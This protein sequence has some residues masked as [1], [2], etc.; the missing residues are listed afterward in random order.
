MDTIGK[1]IMALRKAKGLTQRE[2]GLRVGGYTRQAVGLWENDKR[3]PDYETLTKIAKEL[4]TTVSFLLL[5]HED[6]TRLQ[7]LRERAGLSRQELAEK[8]EV[9]VQLIA[10]VEERE[11]TLEG[12]DLIKV[13]TALN[14][15]AAFLD[16][17]SDDPRIRTQLPPELEQLVDEIIKGGWT[18]DDVR[19]ALRMLGLARGRQDDNDER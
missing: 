16:G 1:R 3:E 10:Q 6:K 14:V 17:T 19:I 4:G 5:G 11:A 18:A 12:I 9:P 15:N 13:A 2:L 8:A 7:I